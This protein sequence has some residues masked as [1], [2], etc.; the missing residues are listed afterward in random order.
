MLDGISYSELMAQ[1]NLRRPAGDYLPHL[2]P[3]LSPRGDPGARRPVFG[4]FGAAQGHLDR[5]GVGP[6]DLF[7]FFGLFR[8]TIATT[9]GLRWR[10]G[11]RPF[12][13]LFGYLAIGEVRR[14]DSL[15]SAQAI[16]F[17]PDHPHV[18]ASPR[19]SGRTTRSSLAATGCRSSLPSPVSAYSASILD[20][21]SRP[22]VR[23]GRRGGVCPLASPPR[24]AAAP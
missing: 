22:K 16:D 2:D 3:D 24:V 17:A 1:L 19:G 6:G 5:Q 8:E 20:C 23:E 9:G 7:L 12:H 4:Q 10:K 13:A 21:G 15:E 14:L 18:T 11:S